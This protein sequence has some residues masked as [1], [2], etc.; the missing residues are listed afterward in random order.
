MTLV[1]HNVPRSLWI[2]VNV[3][4]IIDHHDD[5]GLFAHASPRVIGQTASC[6]TLVVDHILREG[7]LHQNALADYPRELIEL[8]MKTIAIDSKGLRHRSSTDLDHAIAKELH[9]YSSWSDRRT[10]TTMRT[11]YKGV[12]AAKQALEALTVRD[13]LRRD[14]KGDVYVATWDSQ[15]RKLGRD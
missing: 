7:R 1:D 9:A 13:L 2:G 8:L 5:R 11:L 6:S 10:R 15:C 14:W 4:G 12:S 3:T